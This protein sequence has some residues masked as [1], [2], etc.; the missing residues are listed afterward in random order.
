MSNTKLK[1][2][3]F[4]IGYIDWDVRDFHG[5]I[6]KK[7]SSYNSYIIL[8]DKT[9]IIDS[10][11]SPYS[12]TLIENIESHT[13]LDKIDYV[14]CNHAEPDHSG[15]IPVLMSKCCNAVLVCNA[16]CQKALSMHYDTKNW[17][18]QIVDESSELSLGNHT[19]K[20]VNTPM[21][22]WPESMMTYVVEDKILFS[23]DAFGQHY[24][25]SGRF[26]YEEPL[27]V[28]LSEAKTYITQI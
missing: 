22:H 26:D 2:N 27:N 7:G 18:F 19:L 5:Y 17:K 6:T 8:D 24:A 11:K 28:V 10:V 20:F 4:W 3:I 1:E 12:K 16:K 15:S 23:M 25:S 14:I 21:A 13:S 9:A